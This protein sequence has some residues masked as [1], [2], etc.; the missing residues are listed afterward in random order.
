MPRRRTRACVRSDEIPDAR[1]G[2]AIQRLPPPAIT[3]DRGRQPAFEPGPVA[4]KE[5]DEI[6]LAAERRLRV[7]PLEARG[8]P[9]GRSRERDCVS[10]LQPELLRQ[11]H[12]RVGVHRPWH[13]WSLRGVCEYPLERRRHVFPRRERS[14]GHEAAGPRHL[15]RR[16]AGEDDRHEAS[17]FEA[18]QRSADLSTD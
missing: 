18:A 2:Q 4:D 9:F 16:A 11:A 12:A 7:H 13:D 1:F 15:V 14:I 17:R 10:L 6:G 8:E 5:H 3:R